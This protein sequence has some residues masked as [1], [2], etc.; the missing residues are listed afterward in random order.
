MKYHFTST[1]MLTIITSVV[2]I[3]EKLSSTAGGHEQ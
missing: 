1:R 2:E 3:V